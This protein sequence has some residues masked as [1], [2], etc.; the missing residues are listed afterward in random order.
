MP[1]SPGRFGDVRSRRDQVDQSSSSHSPPPFQVVSASPVLATAGV[2]GV[3]A[4]PLL[5]DDVRRLGSRGAS[6]RDVSALAASDTALATARPA[7]EQSNTRSL[8]GQPGA[9][10]FLCGALYTVFY[11]S[12]TV[13]RLFVRLLKCERRAQHLIDRS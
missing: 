1:V 4:S 13:S 9:A 12:S 7:R 2:A 5:A 3:V 10:R 11:C 6:A 8:R